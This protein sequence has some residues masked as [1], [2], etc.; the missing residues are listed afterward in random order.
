MS[1]I[2]AIYTVV[3][4]VLVLLIYKL[5]ART[6]RENF[7]IS[8]TALFCFYLII[9]VVSAV[10]AV[11]LQISQASK[12]MHIQKRISGL[13]YHLMYVSM[14]Q[15]SSIAYQLICVLFM[16][17]GIFLLDLQLLV[18]DDQSQFVDNLV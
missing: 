2:D 7:Q 17:S 16:A 10:P 9:T 13:E 18:V 14:F 8:I 15:C 4:T 12:T 11:Y 1:L 3:L 5:G 6:K